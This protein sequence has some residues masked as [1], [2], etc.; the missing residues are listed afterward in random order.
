MEGIVAMSAKQRKVYQLALEVVHQKLS[1]AEFSSLIGKSYRQSKRIIKK[2]RQKDALGVHH[3][4]LGRTPV[5][6]TS[7]DLED[8]VLTLLKTK[9]YDFNLT[10]FGEMISQREGLVVGKNIIHRI[11]RKGGLVKRPKRRSRKIYKPRVRFPAEGMLVQFD[12]SP[13]IWFANFISDLIVGI[14]DATSKILA[15]EFFIGETSLHCMKVMRDI[16]ITYGTPE[17]YYFDQAGFYGKQD[18]EQDHSQI[19]RALETLGCSAILAGSPQAKGRVERLFNTLQ[20]RLIAEMRLHN[21]RSIPQAN[22]FLQKTFIP[23]FNQQFSVTPRE[24]LPHFKKPDPSWN[25]DLIFCVKEHRK[26]GSAQMFSWNGKTYVVQSKRDYRY[27]TININTHLDGS[28][29]FDVMGIAVPITEYIPQ[30]KNEYYP[31][32]V[33]S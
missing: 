14:D 19:G 2:V 24:K 31:K 28:V 11:A 18:R 17:A 23:K 3:G 8:Q 15:G 33:N 26:I 6:K 16:T 20:D 4:N 32:A 1:I 7:P 13:H 10:H 12:G 22:E 27:R 29:S 5:N 9:Y 30:R 21:I 25:L